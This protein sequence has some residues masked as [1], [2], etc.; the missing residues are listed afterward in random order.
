MYKS[1]TPVFIL[2]FA[3]S[4]NRK[5]W[6]IVVKGFE[7]RWHFSHVFGAVDGEHIHIVPSPDIGSYY[8]NYTA[9]HNVVLM[10]IVKENYEF[11]LAYFGVNGCIADGG[12]LECT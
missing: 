2:K 4:K 3:V 6:E 1:W 7:N 5:E 8:Y 9:T 10:A 11:V 12:V